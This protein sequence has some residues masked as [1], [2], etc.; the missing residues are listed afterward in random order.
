LRGGKKKKQL[1]IS[2]LSFSCLEIT[3]ASKRDMGRGALRTPF[4]S[5]LKAGRL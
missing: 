5:T 2:S 3:L 4:C 1:K